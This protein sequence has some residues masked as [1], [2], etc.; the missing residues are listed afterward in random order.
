MKSKRSI[1]TF[2]LGFIITAVGVGLFLWYFRKNIEIVPEPLIV[3]QDLY[4]K[5]DESSIVVSSES[6]KDQLEKI[7]GIGPVAARKLNNAGIY[8]YRQLGQLMSD[9]LQDITGVTRWDPAEWIVEARKLA[10]N[11]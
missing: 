8:T 7:R 5:P 4:Q 9:Y 2:L 3:S 10:A 11:V 6:D 1:S